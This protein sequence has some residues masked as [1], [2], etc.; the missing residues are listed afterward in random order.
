V[1][2]E[3]VV[4]KALEKDADKRYQQ[5]DELLDDLQSISA[6]IVPEEIKARLR[7][8]KLLKRKRSILYSG[9]VGLVIVI[10]V[11]ALT[12]FTGRTEA[13]ESIAVLPLENL[14]GDEEQQYVVDSVT[15]EL[16]GKLQ[17][18]SGLKRVISRTSVMTFKETDKSLS[19]IARELNVDA[20]VEGTVYQVRDSIRVRFQLTDALPEE[21]NLWSETYERPMRDVLMMYSEVAQVIATELKIGL[22]QEEETRFADARQVN[23]ES[24]DAGLKGKSHMVNFT[25]EG[26]KI[27]LQYF[28]LALEIDPNNALAYVGV[29]NVWAIRY[30]LGMAQRQEAMPLITTPIEKALE[31]D[32]TLAEAHSMLAAY[33]CW[34]E[35]D[36]ESAEKE[37]QQALRLNPNLSKA[38][39][40]YSLFLCHMGRTEEALPHIELVLKLDPLSPLGHHRYGQV[41]RY[42]R[43]YD[44]AIAACRKA[45]EIEPNFRIALGGLAEALGLKGMHDEQ[46][47]IYRKM[48]ADDA[49]LTMAL[50]DGFEKAGY[51]GAYRALA[52]LM[53]EWYGKPGKSVDAT[54]ISLNYL[55]A[56]DYDLAIDWLEKAYEE[57]HP[58]LP[59]L[60]LP[61]YDPLRSDPRFQDLLRKMNLPVDEKE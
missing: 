11:L 10:T 9:A 37:W 60:G 34:S 58:Y 42:H 44:D 16:I 22:T 17:Q 26:L 41:L 7:K 50:E 14:T 18:I 40:S 35:W 33:R 25:P 23:P 24:Y 47:A 52:D 45:L 27:A 51:K 13:I 54:D 43:R 55:N 38:H 19:D 4:E 30:Q 20:I 21:Q 56:G 6:G 57:H 15:D 61:T 3:Q 5:V 36:W 49:E 48:Y 8:A 12:L 29:A 59:F 1:S 53:A 28:D 39:T 32:N 31:L 46:L 2:I